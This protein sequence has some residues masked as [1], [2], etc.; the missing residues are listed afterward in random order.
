MDRSLAHLDPFAPA[1][2]TLRVTRDT[3]YETLVRY[4]PGAD[5]GGRAGHF[6]PGLARSWRVAAGGKEIRLELAPDVTF[7]DGQKLTSVDVQHSLDHA[8]SSHSSAAYLR[9]LLVDITAVELVSPRAL[10]IRLARASGTVL[11]A[12]AEVPIVSARVPGSL[13]RGPVI[14]TGPYRLAA[15]QEGT[16]RLE[17][18]DAYWGEAPAI[19]AIEFVHEPD[20][21]RALTAAKQGGLDILPAL[22]RAHYPNQATAPGLVASFAPLRL[23]P[24]TLRYVA[25][26]QRRPPLD[27]ARVR[28]AIGLLV[29]RDRIAAEVYGG[30]A[31]PVAGPIWPGGP[32]HGRGGAPP[33]FDPQAA[34][35]LLTDAGWI[36]SDGDGLRERDGE[37]LHVAV[38]ALAGET[39]AERATVVRDLRRSGFAVVVREGP[40][41][42]LQNRIRTGDFDLA[43][44][45]WRAPVDVD[46]TPL[47]GT[48]GALNVGGFSHAG[49]DAVL[50][51]L[52]AW[53]SGDRAAAMAELAALVAV[54]APLVAI[55]TPEPYG[56]IHRR[57]RGARVIGG[58]LCLRELVLAKEPDLEPGH[59]GAR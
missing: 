10:R 2:E 39:A 5:D 32:G 4:E 36:D 23:A 46:L 19:A 26:G 59:A 33:V 17:R 42:V 24:P 52:G 7:H 37:R 8:R 29:D 16:I 22:I 31:R 25:L 6:E 13:E 3:V 47:V 35:A 48:G 58:W 45:E 56:L 15:W 54:E 14:G 21:T 43:F 38:L 12:L 44:L 51:R 55:V 41:A 11:R 18:Y 9:M 40:D 28:R 49:I 50:A 27:D 53:E 57:V 34:A 30:L 1:V 20:A